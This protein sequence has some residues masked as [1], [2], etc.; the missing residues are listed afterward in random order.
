[1]ALSQTSIVEIAK[2]C[3]KTVLQFHL[4]NYQPRA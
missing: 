1:M 3:Y 2:M 4:K